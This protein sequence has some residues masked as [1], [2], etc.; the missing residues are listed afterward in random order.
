MP[1]RVRQG[2]GAV[3]LLLVRRRRTGS[4]RTA[5]QRPL[6]SNP[7]PDSLT[8]EDDHQDI[9]KLLVVVAIVNAACRAG[10][11]GVDR[12]YQLKDV[13]QQPM[14]VRGTDD[15]DR[16]SC[17]S[18]FCSVPSEL[19]RAAARRRT[20]TCTRE[21]ARTAAEASLHAAGRSLSRAI[22]IRVDF[23]FRSK[24]I[25]SAPADQLRAPCSASAPAVAQRADRA[26]RRR[27]RHTPASAMP[28]RLTSMFSAAPRSAATSSST[29][30]RRRRLPRCG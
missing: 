18:R 25:A 24:T 2:Q 21:G 6:E 19:E 30:H 14:L 8:D 27:A 26:R 15:A 9:L 7:S 22:A 23:S 20:S 3:R 16:A 11:G 10:H 4:V 28:A 17:T 12:Y 29:R 13:A 1:R 5:R